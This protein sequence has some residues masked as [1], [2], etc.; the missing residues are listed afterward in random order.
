MSEEIFWKGDFNGRA[1]GGYYF[2]NDLFKVFKRLRDEGKN[3]VAIK[4]DDSWNLEVLVEED[5]DADES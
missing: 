3:P 4:V 5:L 1:K 2:R